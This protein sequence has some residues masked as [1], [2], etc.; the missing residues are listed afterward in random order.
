MRS[1]LF[2]LL[3]LAVALL[4]TCGSPRPSNAARPDPAAACCD[5]AALAKCA[6]DST[7]AGCG[8]CD[9]PSAAADTARAAPCPTGG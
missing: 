8:D 6:N 2:I 9:T 3:A 5:S 7:A 1:T 4:A